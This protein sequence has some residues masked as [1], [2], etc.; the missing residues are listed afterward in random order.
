MSPRSPEDGKARISKLG[1]GISGMR[2]RVRQV[3]GRLEIKSGPHGTRITA[4]LPV[5]K[6]TS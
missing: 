1:V 6:A 4:T 5:T 3:G 2:E